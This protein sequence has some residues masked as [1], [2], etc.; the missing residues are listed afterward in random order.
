MKIVYCFIG[1]LPSYSIDT[2][3]QLRLFYS[4][5]IY[6]ILSD[7]Q[8]EY[9]LILK[10]KYNVT[11]V[12]YEEV[13]HEGF[14]SI[15]KQHNNRFYYVNGLAGR[16]NLF[17]Y[18][19]E[20]FFVLYNL[21]DKYNISNVFFLELDNLI[22]D[23]PIKWEESFNEKDASFMM[24]NDGRSSSGVCYIKNKE[25]LLKMND[26]FI[27]FIKSSQKFISEM[28]ALYEIYE[29]YNDN[30]QILPTH[31]SSNNIPE[32]YYKNYNKYENSIFD[33]APIGIFLGGQDIYHTGG[34][35]KTGTVSQ[36]SRIK[37][38]VYKYEWRLDDNNRLIPYIY[39]EEGDKWL[40]INN[41]HIH[42]KN[43][44]AHLSKPIEFK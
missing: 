39:N 30:I 31:W 17:K 34:V 43:L 35:I 44:G 7:Y 27:E 5:E 1:K 23:N 37:Y 22:Y 11:I 16:E 36:W 40:R 19:F 25:I 29:K 38:N 13:I 3:H 33:S 24:D 9:A 10:I 21:M 14:N 18:A 6:F 2:V 26:H 12:K 41:L 8:S 15:C 42:S 20:R 4:G 28:N 32:I